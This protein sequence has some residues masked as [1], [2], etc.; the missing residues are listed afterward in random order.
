MQKQENRN[1][2]ISLRQCVTFTDCLVYMTNLNGKNMWVE[3]MVTETYVHL[4]RLQS[5]T[6]HKQINPHKN[7][8]NYAHI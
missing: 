2:Q 1:F 4:I 6:H 5:N 8:Q 3:V 7:T